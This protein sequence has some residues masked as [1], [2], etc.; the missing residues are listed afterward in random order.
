[1]KQATIPGTEPVE[2]YP[3]VRDALHRW[4]DAVDAAKEHRDTAKRRHDELLDAIQTAKIPYYTYDADGKRKRVYPTVSDPKLRTS[5]VPT[6]KKAIRREPDVGD[7]VVSHRKVSRRSVED[8]IDPF[9]Q[10][11][12]MLEKRDGAP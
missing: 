2:L 3:D 1:M 4:L 8:E 5:T 11:R 10:T 9:A 6:E 7:E 12:S